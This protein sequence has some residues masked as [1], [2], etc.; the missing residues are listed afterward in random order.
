MKDIEQVRKP[1]HLQIPSFVGKYYIRNFIDPSW[2]MLEKFFK[3]NNFSSLKKVETCSF[4]QTH[5]S[6]VKLLSLR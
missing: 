1:F 2:G 3:K 5:K 4:I 6:S